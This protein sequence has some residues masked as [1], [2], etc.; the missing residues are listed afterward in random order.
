MLGEI[1]QNLTV[2]KNN[3][4]KVKMKME[5]RKKLDLLALSS[6]PLVMTLGNS[7]LIPVLPI[8]LKN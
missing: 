4:D 7:M 6:V 8:S 3:I 5:T 2:V 1:K